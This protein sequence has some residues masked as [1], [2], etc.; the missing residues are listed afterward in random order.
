MDF[1]Y[2]EDVIKEVCMQQILVISFTHLASDHS[3]LVYDKR[4]VTA[5]N[6]NRTTQKLMVTFSLF[7][8]VRNFL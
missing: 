2:E 8:N 4:I 6:L 1:L 3:F 5:V 7:S